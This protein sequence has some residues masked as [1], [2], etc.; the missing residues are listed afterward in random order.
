M[1]KHLDNLLQYLFMNNIFYKSEVLVY[2]GSLSIPEIDNIKKNTP[3]DVVIF[4]FYDK[5]NNDINETLFTNSLILFF[6]INLISSELSVAITCLRFEHAKYVSNKNFTVNDTDRLK[7]QNIITKTLNDI[8]HEHLTALISLRSSICNLSYI[9]KTN[10]KITIDSNYPAIICSAGPSLVKSL[11]VLKKYSD[12]IFIVAVG[13]ALPVLLDNEITPDCIVEIESRSYHWQHNKGSD[14]ILVAGTSVSSVIASRF[15]NIIWHKT[16]SFFFNQFLEVN[17]INLPTM[18]TSY[19]VTASAIDFITNLAFDN[20][21]LIGN[22]LA[23]S[24]DKAFHAGEKTNSKF[25]LESLLS[26]K[27]KTGENI[28][29]TKMFLKLKLG[30]EECIAELRNEFSNLKIFNCSE[31]GLDIHNTR[32][33][34]LNKFLHRYSKDKKQYNI[35]NDIIP[36]I[37]KSLMIKEIDY[38]IKSMDCRSSEAIN[39]PLIRDFINAIG[40]YIEG[41][42]LNIKR[43]YNNDFEK[44][45]MLKNLLLDIKQDLKTP[46]SEKEQCFKFNAFRIYAISFI[47]NNNIELAN[48]LKNNNLPLSEDFDLYSNMIDIPFVKMKDKDNKWIKF[49]KDFSEIHKEA[50][51]NVAKFAEKNNFDVNKHSVIFK[52]PR[53][54]SIVIEFIK[55]YPNADIMIIEPYLSLFSDLISRFPFLHLFPNKTVIIADNKILKNQNEVYQKTIDIWKNNKTTIQYF[56]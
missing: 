40:Y 41:L 4:Y 29:T 47:R 39:V 28:F 31:C 13:H 38:Y 8:R 16:N 32:N 24:D 33:S 34:K 46:S 45:K 51:D 15:K 3:D 21:A 11:D 50:K 49:N 6:D 1:N 14:S 53:N 56:S 37:D 35:S 25:D 2:F 54:W 17:K 27:S 23:L 9:P 52:N 7:I 18:K 12:K 43:L 55:R 44:K 10:C 42:F 30:I 22:D 5:K 48:Y 26:V 20:I 19:S 36:I